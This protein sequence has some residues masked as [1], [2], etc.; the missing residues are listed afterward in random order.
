M[1]RVV[2][3]RIARSGS[4]VLVDAK[5]VNGAVRLQ[6]G[7]LAAL[8]T[9]ADAYLQLTE[10]R[11]DALRALAGGALQTDC[12]QS[13]VLLDASLT[14]VCVDDQ[15]AR[16][17]HV[18]T[19]LGSVRL[20]SVAGVGGQAEAS[21]LS[22]TCSDV[23][24]SQRGDTCRPL[25]CLPGG[26]G[27]AEPAHR[28]EFLQASRLL[29]KEGSAG[30]PGKP[31]PKSPLAE[32]V[33][34]V[35]VRGAQLQVHPDDPTGWVRALVAPLG[36]G[37]GPQLSEEFVPPILHVALHMEDCAVLLQ[38]PSV[39]CSLVCSHQKMLVIVW[40]V[41]MLSIH[42]RRQWHCWAACG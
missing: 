16:G 2:L 25:L 28:L 5:I 41:V 14:L 40:A 23:L 17:T 9:V 27:T 26:P 37:V 20:L 42:R 30:S 24:V 31:A 3:E 39:R 15:P 32:A 38:T 29:P 1:D 33:C 12:V 7:D 35:Y 21:V 13:S 11:T 34:S 6:A 22:L 10:R 4:A 19:A 36:G 18:A 8:W